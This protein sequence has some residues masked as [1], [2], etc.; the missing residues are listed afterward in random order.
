M[1]LGRAWLW[2]RHDNWVGN[3]YEH[4]TQSR[5]S[6]LFGVYSRGSKIS[7]TGG[8]CVTCSGL[9]N[10]RWTINALQ[11]APSS[12]YEK[13]RKRKTRLWTEQLKTCKW[14]L[15][16]GQ[17]I[18]VWHDCHQDIRLTT[19]C[20]L[21]GHESQLLWHSI[22]TSWTKKSTLHTC[23]KHIFPYWLPLTEFAFC[24]Q[25]GSTAHDTRLLSLYT[26]AFLCKAIFKHIYQWQ[27]PLA[28]QRLLPNTFY[29][30]TVG[31]WV[32]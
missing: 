11:R 9:T 25:L 3:D 21:I 23:L 7:H 31:G 2:T 32:I 29:R 5:W 12:I 14:L 17:D 20:V 24:W 15:H 27:L 4:D 6:L 16:Y 1:K 13:E 10:S 30:R 22:F 26:S 8:K 18:Q 19:T 28:S